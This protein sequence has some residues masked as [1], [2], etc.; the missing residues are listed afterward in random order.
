MYYTAFIKASPL[1]KGQLG[2]EGTVHTC[3]AVRAADGRGNE[4]SL[5]ASGWSTVSDGHAG[6]PPGSCIDEL[7]SLLASVFLVQLVIGNT[8]EHLVPKVK[9]RM[10][11]RK[12]IVAVSQEKNVCLR[13]AASLSRARSDVFSLSLSLSL[14][15]HISLS[16]H[17]SAGVAGCGHARLGAA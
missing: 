3:G 7:T 2:L 1:I 4:T 14:S 15:F 8:M 12:E 17:L 11:G 9:Q 10:R 16:L 5:N 6:T 13:L